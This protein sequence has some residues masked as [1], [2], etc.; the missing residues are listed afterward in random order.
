MTSAAGLVLASRSGGASARL[1]T[2]KPASP[3]LGSYRA[4]QR[5]PAGSAR[6]RRRR[7]LATSLRQLDDF[8]L[9]VVVGEFNAGKS[10]LINALLGERVVDEGVTPTTAQIEMLRYGDPSRAI[11]AS[12]MQIVT[13]PMALFATPHRGYPGTNAINRAH[14]GLTPTSCP[15]PIWCCSSPRPTGRSPKP[16]VSFSR[17][18]RLGQRRSSGRQQ[19]RHL[20][21]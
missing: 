17:S 13:A 12:G 5:Y 16:S 8:F 1:P 3:R 6:R 20:R 11:D 9:L 19:G 14:E 15:A 10:A 7:A 2:S 18:S 4:A 21:E